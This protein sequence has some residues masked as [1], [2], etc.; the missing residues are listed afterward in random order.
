MDKEQL[1]KKVRRDLKLDKLMSLV[2][3]FICVLVYF[4]WIR[5]LYDIT[6]FFISVVHFMI[7]INAML[8]TKRNLNTLEVMK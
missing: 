2:S 5:R 6:Y 4:F 7:W 3:L 1:I 8:I